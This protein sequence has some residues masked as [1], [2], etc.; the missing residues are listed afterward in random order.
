MSSFTVI[1]P[2]SIATVVVALSST[3]DR[4]SISVPASVRISSVCNGRI[5]LTEPTSVVLPT[6]KPPAITILT[7]CGIRSA[8]AGRE[9]PRGRSERTKPIDHRLEHVLLRPVRRVDRLLHHDEL[10]VEQVPD[11]DA[12][13]PERE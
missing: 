4:S 5:S 6:P 2:K 13:H 10:R 12:D 11:Q 3:P 1:R 9:P 7:A 8:R